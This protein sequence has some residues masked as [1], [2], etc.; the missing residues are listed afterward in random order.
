MV[1]KCGRRADELLASVISSSFADK[2]TRTSTYRKS[3]DTVEIRCD[4]AAN[5][6]ALQKDIDPVSEILLKSL[7]ESECRT[8]KSRMNYD[9]L[10]TTSI[11]NITMANLP[12]DKTINQ[13][14]LLLLPMINFLK[15]HLIIYLLF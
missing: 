4:W 6:T 15:M 8:Q 3:C 14:L 12:L 13:F 5:R 2:G 1:S 10:V 11:F 7:R 9:A